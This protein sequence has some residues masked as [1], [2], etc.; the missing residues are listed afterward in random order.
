MIIYRTNLNVLSVADPNFPGQSSRFIS[1]S[2]GAFLP[3]ESKANANAPTDL[4][5]KIQYLAKSAIISSEGIAAHYEDM[6]AGTIGSQE[7]YFFHHPNSVYY[8]GKGMG[9]FT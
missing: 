6:L 7:P 1:L 5:P 3:Y 8:N 2:N 9:K 4:L